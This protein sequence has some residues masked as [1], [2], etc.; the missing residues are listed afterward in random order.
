LKADFKILFLKISLALLIISIVN[1]AFSEERKTKPLGIKGVLDLT[2]WDFEKDGPVNLDGSW[3]FYWKQLLEPKDFANEKSPKLTGFISVPSRWTSYKINGETLPGDGYATFR[4]LINVKPSVQKISLKLLDMGTAY[5]LWINENQIASNGT[6]GIS[7]ETMVPKALPQVA[8][9]R[10]DKNKLQIVIQVSNFMHKSGGIW[11]S[12]AVGETEEIE[13]IRVWKVSIEML[14]FGSILI[15]GPYHLALFAIR[16]KNLSNLYFGILCLL[17]T[18]RVFSTGE[19][20]FVY[21]LDVS[22]ETNIKIEYLSFYLSVTGFSMFLESL[23]P[24]EMSKRFVRLSQILGVLFGFIVLL[25]PAKVFSHTILTYQVI[26]LLSGLYGLYVL[27]IAKIRKRE[28]AGTFFLGF[29]CFFLTIIN[30]VL[31]QN[32]II[33]TG[34]WVPFGLFMFIFFQAFLLATRFSTAFQLSENLTHSYGRFVPH[35][36]LDLLDK[37]S[38]L[39][40]ELGD[41]VQKEMTIL[42]SDIR[43]FTTLSEGMTPKENFQFIN[44]YLSQMGPLV[45]THHGFI[46]KYIGDTVM[47]LFDKSADDAVQASIAML[48]L[49]EDYNNAQLKE[50]KASI[51]I[52]I[53]INTGMLMLGTVGEE[54]RMEG[55]VISDSVN[56]AE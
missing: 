11:Y 48:R 2:N 51:K 8:S 9:F 29:L 31:Y 37:E 23:F 47:A 22:W 20:L 1:L 49:L 19:R 45:R 38:I 5:R 6:V 41:Q 13:R 52:G 16:R 7:K 24:Q 39:K 26:T 55:T 42:F 25:T 15:M 21:L 34:Y 3:E 46:D 44:N 53:G 40:V 56:I 50:G 14:L 28:G 17:I 27:I 32:E 18:M 30:D 36:F 43:S 33:N 10:L 54:D 35:E 12:L 4:L